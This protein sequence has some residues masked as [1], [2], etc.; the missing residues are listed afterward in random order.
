MRREITVPG[1]AG[2]ARLD[3]R[4]FGGAAPATR[5]EAQRD[6]D[7]VLYSSAF[8]RLGHVTQVTASETGLS[9]HSRLTHSLKV[10]Q[11]SRRLAERLISVRTAGNLSGGAERAVAALCPDA[12]ETAA[13]A[14]DLGHPPFGH[15]AEEVLND[16]AK[17]FGG[18][19][20]NAQS[21]RI[22]TFLS[23]RSQDHPGLNLTR[24]SLNGVIKYP[25]LRNLN[26]TKTSKKWNAY[27]DEADSFD[28][29]RK[30]SKPELPSLE[31]AIMD[32][33]D[34]VT[35]AVHDMEDFYR[36]GL[37]PLD[38][39]ANDA[40]ELS[41]FKEHL[42][43]HAPD[44]STGDAWADVADDVFGALTFFETAYSGVAVERIGV[45]ATGSGLITRY[46]NAP[47]IESAKGTTSFCVDEGHRHEVDVLKQLIWC[48]VIER[49][50]LA[51]MQSG[52]REI[53]RYLY[54]RYNRAARK[55]DH[56]L[57][58]LHYRERLATAETEPAMSR[59][60]VDLVAGL[61]EDGAA[62]IYRRMT[63]TTAGSVGDAAGRLA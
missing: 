36:A 42:K 21:F 27:S 23:L 34:D 33:A 50:S 13:L 25:W 61:T 8:H 54:K 57:F 41:G 1:N 58:P 55:G 39:L 2:V 28:W 6:R 19:E 14:H 7:R 40:R 4:E 51:I 16:V 26:R 56:R 31:A 18:F 35:Y 10:A 48:Y 20:G 43:K 29:V 3:K 5:S 52:Q 30:H 38:R 12:A 37:L 53:I 32:W 17:G 9:F 62:E 63:G 15:L 49:P 46:M 45:R 44:A 22:L 47:T 11:F 60:V 59:I 24:R